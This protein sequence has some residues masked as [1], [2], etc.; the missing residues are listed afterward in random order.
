MTDPKRQRALLEELYHTYIQLIHSR[1]IPFKEPENVLEMDDF[2]LS[3]L[4][5]ELKDVVRTP[6][7]R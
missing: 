5:A 6:V 3:N 7:A 1:G 4:V 2:D